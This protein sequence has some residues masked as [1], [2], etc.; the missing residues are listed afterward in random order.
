MVEL[1][2]NGGPF[3]LATSD[4][5]SAFRALYSDGVDPGIHNLRGAGSRATY[6]GR[7]A[8]PMR[9]SSGRVLAPSFVLMCA[10]VF[11]TVL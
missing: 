9:T 1:S 11:A 7:W 4:P 3:L 8:M 5:R 6:E 2:E 10:A